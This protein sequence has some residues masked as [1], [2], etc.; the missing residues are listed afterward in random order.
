MPLVVAC[1]TGVIYLLL[2]V[3]LSVSDF[4]FCSLAKEAIGL[5]RWILQ[6]K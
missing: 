1:K 2:F 5:E 4:R 6:Q 3:Y